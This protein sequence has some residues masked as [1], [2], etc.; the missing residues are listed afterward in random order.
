MISCFRTE[1]VW[2]QLE[3]KDG[4][5]MVI[6]HN[7]N[8]V[9]DEA[10]FT[11]GGS[12]FN[13]FVVNTTSGAIR[14]I[15]GDSKSSAFQINTPTG[16]LGLRGTAFD[17]QHY[18]GQTYIMLIDGEVTFCDAAGNCTN[19]SRR[20][21][22]MAIGPNG[23][24]QAPAQPEDGIYSEEDMEKFFPFIADQGDLL[25]QFKKPIK[26]CGGGTTDPTM[27][28]NRPGNDGPS[29]S[30]S[31][32]GTHGGGGFTG[33]GGNFGGGGN[34]GGAGTTGGG[35]NSI[36]DGGDGPAL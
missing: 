3:F 19:I 8:V 9:L 6:G 12:Q 28:G 10:V 11:R 26:L 31:G 33:G 1:P 17:M 36:S 15:S 23:V 16:T 30:N 7:A 27:T 32:G 22:C 4:T 34:T 18:Q 14:F 35:G 5:K 20:C 21:D 25:K 13:R 24:I 29:S 2:A